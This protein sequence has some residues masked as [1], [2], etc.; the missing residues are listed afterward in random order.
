M[1][2]PNHPLYRELEAIV[3]S[4]YVADDDFAVWA[5]SADTSPYSRKIPGIIV[6]PA[7]ID[8][9]VEKARNL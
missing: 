4:K 9:V 1:R 2:M 6:R 7:N 5:Y 8:E 3:G